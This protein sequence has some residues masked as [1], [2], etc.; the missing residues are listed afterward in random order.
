M[1]QNNIVIQISSS[2]RATSIGW[3]IEAERRHATRVREGSSW[4]R[5]GM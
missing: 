4:R 1:Q 5:R 3:D 2:T